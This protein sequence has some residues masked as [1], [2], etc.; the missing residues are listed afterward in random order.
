MCLHAQQRPP[1]QAMSGSTSPGSE[2]GPETQKH[3][4]L[5]NKRPIASYERSIPI[6]QR[7]LCARCCVSVD[8][9]ALTFAFLCERTEMSPRA[10]VIRCTARSAPSSSCSNVEFGV[11]SL[12]ERA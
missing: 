2:S 8:C 9:G 4:L 11:N 3:A 12:P 1:G 7:H 10:P 6:I 5:R